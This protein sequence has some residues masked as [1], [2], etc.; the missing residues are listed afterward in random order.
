MR[1]RNEEREAA[2]RRMRGE[3]VDAHAEYLN[4]S[5][6]LR[7]KYDQCL[8]RERA[9]LMKLAGISDS[10]VQDQFDTEKLKCVEQVK[11]RCQ[12]EDDSWLGLVDWVRSQ[13]YKVRVL[14]REN[15]IRDEMLTYL[16][17]HVDSER[18]RIAR[19]ESE[20]M[21]RPLCETGADDVD[22]MESWLI[23]RGL[24]WA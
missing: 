8:Q 6:E 20:A 17:N 22:Q 11:D 24:D 19:I 5:D 12:S 14:E 9:E 2:W 18:Y 1:A 10:R 15:R 3:T 4:K 23:E 16:R 13:A 21:H 7:T